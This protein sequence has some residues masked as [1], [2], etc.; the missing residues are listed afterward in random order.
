M[1][2][3]EPRERCRATFKELKILTVTSLYILETI[4]YCL[5]RDLPRNGDFHEYNTRHC[6]DFP[7]PPHR[8]AVFEKN[9]P[10]PERNSFML[11]QKKSRKS[12]Q[13]HK[14]EDSNKELAPAKNHLY[15][16]RILPVET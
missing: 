1:G 2:K 3:L 14:N 16:R 10:M 8:T 6:Q 5:S 12:R 11:C 4:L 7:L 9:Q 15:S 13:L